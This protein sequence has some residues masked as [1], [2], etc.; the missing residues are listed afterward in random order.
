MESQ[1]SLLC[2]GLKFAI[3]S[4]FFLPFELLYRDIQNLDVTDQKK[5]LLKARI[6]E[7]ALSS[8][9]SYDKNS[10]PLN[11]TREEFASLKS[12]SKMTV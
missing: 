8:F 4:D 2:K 10:A 1:K 5:Q 7:N 11:L 3:P 12:L 6:K 9:N